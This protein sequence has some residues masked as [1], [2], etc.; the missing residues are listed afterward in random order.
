MLWEIEIRPLPSEI[1]REAARIQSSCQSMRLSSINEIRAAKSFLIQGDLNQEQ[2]E[3][4]AQTFLV[5]TVVEAH[6]IHPL[7]KSSTQSAND[8]QLLNVMFKYL[9][10]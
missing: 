6:A 5:D 7:S 1:D 4:A 10:D 9:R 3:R 8:A 2:I